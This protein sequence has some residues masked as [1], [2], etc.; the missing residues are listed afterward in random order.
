MM[1]RS[2]VRRVCVATRWALGEGDP[3][4][5]GA[6]VV[7]PSEAAGRR[8]LVKAAWDRRRTGGRAQLGLGLLSGGVAINVGLLAPDGL[9]AGLGALSFAVGVGVSQVVL[10]RWRKER[11]VP[12]P[13]RR[14]PW[15]A[16]E[17]EGTLEPVGEAE[18]AAKGEAAEEAAPLGW[19]L[20]LEVEGGATLVAG[21]LQGAVVRLDDGQA[22]HVPAGPV[23]LEGP[24]HP[25]S[26]PALEEALARLELAAL[27]APLQGDEGLEDAPAA[28][29]PYRRASTVTLEVGARVRV[30]GPFAPSFRR[31]E[32]RGAFR[33]AASRELAPVGLPRLSLVE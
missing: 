11:F 33:T 6:A 32:E 26:G 19:Q 22:V 12:A 8:T 9:G 20:R 13:G 5:V 16:E 29:F 4:P 28:P 30:A 21:V 27:V 31:G 10:G 7:D 25:L 3:S 15:P 17:R 1:A 14:A 24:P 18:Q 23:H 2:P